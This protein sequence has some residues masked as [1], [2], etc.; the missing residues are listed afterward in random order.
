[1]PG[2]LKWVGNYE[3]TR[4]FLVLQI[5]R[6]VKDGLNRLLHLCNHT[7]AQF[8]QPPLYAKSLPARPSQSSTSPGHGL[9]MTDHSDCFHISLAW[10]LSEPSRKERELVEGTDLK[11]LKGL[12]VKFDSVKVKIGNHVESLQLLA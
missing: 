10:T 3:K 12:H 11:S 2:T 1:M 6:P 5:K 7:L 8:D 4:W 9:Q